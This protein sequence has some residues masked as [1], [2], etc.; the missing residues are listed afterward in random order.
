MTPEQALERALV[1]GLSV[2][3]DVQAVLGTPARL[4]ARPTGRPAYPYAVIDRHR[5]DLHGDSTGQ[6][7]EHRIDLAVF[8]RHGGRAEARDALGQLRLA[9]EGLSLAPEGQRIIL[10]HTV[11]ADTMRTAQLTAFRGLMRLRILMEE[12]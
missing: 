5:I 9:F 2:R 10:A 4:Y 6:A 11:Y 7:T 3:A 12:L 1:D 8:T